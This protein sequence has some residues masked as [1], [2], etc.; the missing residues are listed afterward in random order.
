[1]KNLIIA[2]L[3][4]TG[5]Q[6]Q[7]FDFECFS[8]KEWLSVSCEDQLIAY[9][10]LEEDFAEGWVIYTYVTHQI[11]I[12]SLDVRS[13]QGVEYRN[14]NKLNTF[15]RW[16]PNLDHSSKWRVRWCPAGCGTSPFLTAQSAFEF[17]I[18]N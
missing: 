2:L 18:N 8:C 11:T 17:A 3:C 7:T 5:V 1:M 12:T 9:N 10:I 14:I 4:F 16:Y 15:V 6:A 13:E